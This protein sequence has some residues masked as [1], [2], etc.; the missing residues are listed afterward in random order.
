LIYPV[1]VLAAEKLNVSGDL[2]WNGSLADVLAAKGLLA[3][4]SATTF[5]AALLDPAIAATCD[6]DPGI[7]WLL[8]I[9]LNLPEDG[10]PIIY[11]HDY[12]RGDRFSFDVRRHAEHENRPG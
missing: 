4:M 5:Q 6:I 10:S 7:P 2:D 8:M 12:H 9:Q 11:S 1:D 3:V